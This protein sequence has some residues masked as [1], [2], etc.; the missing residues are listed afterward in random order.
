[1]MYAA[2]P[3]R[4]RGFTLVE[5]LVALLVMSIGLLG[6][7]KLVLVS[8]RANDSA[9]LRSQATAL[10]YEALDDMRANRL[11]AVGG[12]YTT[13]PNWASTA[14]SNPG[15]TCTAACGNSTIAQLDLYNWQQHLQNALGPSGDG[16]ISMATTTDPVTLAPY[17]A[18]T[19]TVKWDDTVAQQ[20]FGGTP[21]ATTVV[22]E[23]I[24]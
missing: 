15:T 3:T 21:G 11:S 17:T 16:Q 12:A 19:V 14:A 1:M 9:Y 10:A 22:L 13:A 20:A 2:H 7:G 6:I 5:V 24:L 23:T 18:V 4:L 8:A